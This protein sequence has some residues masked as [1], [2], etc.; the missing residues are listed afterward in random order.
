MNKPHIAFF[1]VGFLFLYGCGS[2]VTEDDFRYAEQLV[3]IR[4][5]SLVHSIRSIRYG[6]NA[7][8]V[9]WKMSAS[10]FAEY[11]RLLSNKGFE[12]WKDIQYDS[13]DPSSFQDKVLFAGF[14][15]GYGS[16][17]TIGERI[18]HKG[19]SSIHVF[20]DY[21]TEEFI[22]IKSYGSSFIP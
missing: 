14:P 21:T 8:L 6:D 9:G 3:G 2:N 4:P 5:P 7:P 20:Y 19:R 17:A 1:L 15:D 16:H 13:K 22:A 11:R 18:I 12:E 10:A